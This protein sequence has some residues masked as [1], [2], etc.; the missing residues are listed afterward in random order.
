MGEGKVG[1]VDMK[2][3]RGE[4]RVEREKSIWEGRV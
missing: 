2:G 1:R 4:R 3:D